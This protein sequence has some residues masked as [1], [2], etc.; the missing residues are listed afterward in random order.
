MKHLYIIRHGETIFNK[1]YKIQGRGIDASLNQAG[2]N[3]GKDVAN[4]LQNI[5]ITKIITSSL[6]RTKETALPLSVSKN[7]PIQSYKELDEMDFGVLEG[8]DI[9]EVKSKLVEIQQNWAAGNLNFKPESG[10]SPLEVY[11]RANNRIKDVLNTTDA[12]HIAIFIHGRLIRVLLSEWIDKG[13][14]NMHNIKHVNGAINYL[15][16]ENDKFKSVYLNKTSH[17]R[18]VGTHLELISKE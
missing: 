13:L 7:I 9:I 6:K 16:F 5:P 10:E 17:L 2:I 14:I 15:S 3:Q 1:E 8:Q 11:E 12:K 18:Y 4:E